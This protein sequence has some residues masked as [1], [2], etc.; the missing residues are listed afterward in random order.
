MLGKI[1]AE[2]RK[3]KGYTFRNLEVKTGYAYEYFRRAEC[4]AYPLS[5]K[6]LFTIYGAYDYDERIAREIEKEMAIKFGHPAKVFLMTE[7]K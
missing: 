5:L 4:G 2:I 1:L 3:E 6:F 7:E